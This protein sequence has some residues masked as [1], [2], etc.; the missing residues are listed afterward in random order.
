MIKVLK[1]NQFDIK[2]RQDDIQHA[3]TGPSY[4]G[5]TQIVDQ[6]SH[7]CDNKMLSWASLS[8]NFCWWYG[9]LHAWLDHFTDA[10]ERMHHLHLF[11]LRSATYQYMPWPYVHLMGPVRPQL[12]PIWPSLDPI[13]TT[14]IKADTT[15]A[16]LIWNKNNGRLAWFACLR[17]LSSL[18]GVAVTWVGNQTV[19]LESAHQLVWCGCVRGRAGSDWSTSWSNF[20]LSAI[21]N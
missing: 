21:F 5:V 9:K 2:L 8:C 4:R 15:S 16:I 11:Y 3:P 18:N 6:K 1:I 10:S 20:R 19:H 7:I 17:S 12:W 13:W 14:L